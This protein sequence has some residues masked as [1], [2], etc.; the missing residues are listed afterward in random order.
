MRTLSRASLVVLSALAL[1][2]CTETAGD[3]GSEPLPVTT[4][5]GGGDGGGGSTGDGGSTGVGMST[6]DG[7]SGTTTGPGT[8]SSTTGA[9]AGMPGPCDGGGPSIVSQGSNTRFLLKGTILLPSGPLQGE[10]L[11]DGNAIACVGAS[12]ANAPAASGATVIETNGI[13]APGM[14]DGHNH[15]L[16]DIFDETDWTPDPMTAIGKPGYD[17]HD[18]WPNEPKYKA[19]VD[20]K[21]YL[22]GEGSAVD[23]GCEMLKFGETKALVAG[24]TSVVGA[25]GGAARN[26]FGSV[27]RSLDINKND[28]PV[29]RMQTA[30]IFPSTTSADGVCTNFSDG[31]T[32]AYVIH[33]AEGVDDKSRAEFDKLLT[34]STTDGCLYDPR[35]TI[36]HGTALDQGRLVTA[37][38]EGMNLIWSPRSNVF[39]YGGGTDFSKTTDIPAALGLGIEVAI[40]PDWSLGGSQNLL[41]ELRFADQVDNAEWNDLLSPRDL[42]EMATIH[43]ANVLG[44]SEYLGSLEEGKRADVVVYLPVANDPYD[45]ILASTPREVALVFVDGRLLYGDKGF[46]AVAPDNAIC[47]SFDGCCRE[48]TLCIAETGGA[49]ADRFDQTLTQI[50]SILNQALSDYDAMNLSAWDFAPVTA[51]VKCWN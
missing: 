18:Q 14:L 1:P 45:A 31:D 20:T 46:E 13:V 22:N 44:V 37:A 19:L 17:N 36:V 29:D 30:T 42:F 25:P 40:A 33:I 5:S 15:I 27:A 38:N 11:I 47:E 10:L 12:C 41:D 3:D 9:G 6:G 28:L 48:K 2:A 35:T 39:L 50:I 7:G 4:S 21:Q 51:V 16:F 49:A 23:F 32:N 24:T 43:S 26:C 34:I 8:T